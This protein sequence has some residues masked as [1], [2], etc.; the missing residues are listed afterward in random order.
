MN[1]GGGEAD[2]PQ[3]LWVEHVTGVGGGGPFDEP[4]GLL[5]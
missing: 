2:S 5:I 4:K 3:V 1:V